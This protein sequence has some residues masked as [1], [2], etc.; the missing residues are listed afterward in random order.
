MSNQTFLNDPQQEILSCLLSGKETIQVFKKIYPDILTI[1]YQSGAKFI[2]QMWKRYKDSSISKRLDIRIFRMLLSVL[3]YRQG[4]LPFYL[5]ASLHHIPN[6]KFD[7]I[8]YSREYGPVILSAKTSLRERYKQADLEGMM[9]RQVHR[10]AKSYLIT[11][12]EPAARLVN[13]KIQ[14]GQVLG[15]DDVVVASDPKFDQLIEEIRKLSFYTPEKIEV[16][17][18]KRLIV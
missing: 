3:F 18:G 2:E 16:L 6:I 1:K 9:V 14:N 15:L 4:V 8:A 12:D 13:E 11:L 17:T 10:K 7:F 5:N